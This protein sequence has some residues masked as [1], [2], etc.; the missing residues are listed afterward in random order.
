M[1]RI[2]EIKN[3]VLFALARHKCYG[4]RGFKAGHEGL[5]INPNATALQ[6]REFHFGEIQKG[7]VISKNIH[8]IDFGDYQDRLQDDIILWLPSAFDTRT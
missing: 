2:E 3:G 4:S 6:I 5:A 7:G 1:L 8:E